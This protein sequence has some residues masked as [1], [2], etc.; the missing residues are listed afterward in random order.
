[1]GEIKVRVR[2]ENHDDR[3]L[4]KAGRIPEQDIRIQEV[5][6]VVD[7]CAVLLMLPQD[8]VE[9]LGLESFGKVVVTLANEQKVEMERAG[10]LL[11]TVCGR[12]MPT[13]CLVGPPGC[14][15][16]VGQ[17]ILE[18]LDLIPD[19]LKRTLTPRPESPY[20]PTLKLK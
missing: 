8:L 4:F 12:K 13:D 17:L 10:Y 14:E 5:E 15:P 9:V 6:A 18:S 7:T 1:M 16:L 3:V 2:L 20:L 11:L 19:P